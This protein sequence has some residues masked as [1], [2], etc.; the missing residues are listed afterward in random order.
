[1]KQLII[2]T[3]TFDCAHRIFGH[4]FKCGNFHGHTYEVELT[5]EF[6]NESLYFQ[7]TGYGIDF[8]ELKRIGLGWI[9]KNWD[10]AMILSPIE[11]DMIKLL[12]KENSNFYLMSLRGKGIHCNPSA[13]NMAKELYLAMEYLFSKK[14]IKI[15]KVKLFETKTSSSICDINSITTKEKSNFYKN[16]RK[17]MGVFFRNIPPIE[18]F[19]K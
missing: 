8:T 5:F 3:G 13:E 19:E 14:A 15:K 7:K 10:H 4:L 12:K 18:Y 17:E 1:M 9:D 6:D 11:H 2:K 16:K